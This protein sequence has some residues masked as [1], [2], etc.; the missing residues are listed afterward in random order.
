M[1]KHGLAVVLIF[2]GVKIPVSAL[3]RLV[4]GGVSCCS[5]EPA[6]WSAARP[7]PSLQSAF[8]KVGTKPHSVSAVCYVVCGAVLIRSVGMPRSL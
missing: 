4:I 3:L 7:V 1:L 2:V 5:P 6:V 8:A